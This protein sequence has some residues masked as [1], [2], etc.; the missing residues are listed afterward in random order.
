[1]KT[2]KSF[3]GIISLMLFGF[4]VFQSCAAKMADSIEGKGGTAGEAGIGVAFILLIC[5]ATSLATRSS[6]NKGN[7]WGLVI[8]YGIGAIVGYTKHG[9]FKDLMV[10]GSWCLICA[11][12]ILIYLIKQKVSPEPPAQFNTDNMTGNSPNMQQS[13]PSQPMSEEMKNTEILK[14]YKELLD[15]GAISQEEFDKKKKDLL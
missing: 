5:G 15:I 3:S 14:K 8:L 1:M 10:W 6:T 11:V 13:A 2:W 7:D 12:V 9:V 4:V